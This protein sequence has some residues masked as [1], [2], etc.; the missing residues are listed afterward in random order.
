MLPQKLNE[1]TAGRHITW[2]GAY[3]DG[4]VH[5][6]FDATLAMETAE[7]WRPSW[8]KWSGHVA[9]L[10][11]Q[12]RPHREA[13]SVVRQYRAELRRGFSLDRVLS[14]VGGED[15]CARR[16]GSMLRWTGRRRTAMLCPLLSCARNAGNANG[17]PAVRCGQFHLRDE[18]RVLHAR[19]VDGPAA[20]RLVRGGDI[21]RGRF[22][23]EGT[24][25]PFRAYDHDVR[26]GRSRVGLPHGVGGSQG[27]SVRGEDFARPECHSAAHVADCLL[28][29]RWRY[30]AIPGPRW[31]GHPVCGFYG[32]AGNRDRLLCHGGRS[33]RGLLA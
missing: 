10:S 25:R 32:G 11:C 21:L 33:G 16:F 31:A 24:W 20:N 19:T 27:H 29:D 15:H 6:L 9:R 4:N 7:S 17:F 13:R 23:S 14:A 18:G 12:S 30:P 26:G 2:H 22:H 28:P 1:A 5:I 8:T 3:D